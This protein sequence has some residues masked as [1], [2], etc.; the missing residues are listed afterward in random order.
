M[1]LH[2]VLFVVFTLGANISSPIQVGQTVYLTKNDCL[3]AAAQ[4]VFTKP[5]NVQLSHGVGRS[6]W[7]ARYCHQVCAGRAQVRPQHR[8]RPH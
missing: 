1:E 7:R 2:W 8:P 6:D 5:G 3:D 4:S